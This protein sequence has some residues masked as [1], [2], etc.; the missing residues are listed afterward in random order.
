MKLPVNV[1]RRGSGSFL[2]A[3]VRAEVSWLM[4]KVPPRV[5]N[6]AVTCVA[7]LL[8]VSPSATS[9]SSPPCTPDTWLSS[10]IVLD[11][12][13]NCLMMFVTSVWRSPTML[14]MLV[15]AEV[16]AELP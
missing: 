4:V 13:S 2:A 7:N 10:G 9:L 8:K 5:F 16:S 12:C 6:P 3:V 11:S 1:K 15:M 14:V